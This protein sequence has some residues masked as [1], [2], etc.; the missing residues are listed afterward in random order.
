MLV[1]IFRNILTLVGIV[2][3]PSLVAEIV[4]HHPAS[5]QLTDGK[6]FVVRDGPLEK[7]ACFRCPGGCGEKLMLSLVPERRPRWSVSIDWLRRP[8]VRPSVW[9]QNECGCHFWVN[10]GAVQ[11]CESGRPRPRT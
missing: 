8:S 10:N 4:P 2:R 7:W 11:W 3:R 9:Q 5:E 1:S 6:L